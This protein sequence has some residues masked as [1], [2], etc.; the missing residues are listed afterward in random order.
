[1]RDSI[2]KGFNFGLTSGTITT[3]GLIIGLQSGTGSRLAVLGGVLTI[4][5]ADSFSDALGIHMSEESINGHSKKHVW[6]ATI[7]TFLAKL[8]FTLTF[9]IPVLLFNLRLAILISIIWGFLLLTISSYKIAKDQ[10]DNPWKVIG[11][12]LLIGLIVVI[13]THYLGNLIYEIFVK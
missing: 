10:D 9:A 1:M 12:H 13:S 4:A 7:F 5:I 6:E 2:K 3:L 11:E 8:I